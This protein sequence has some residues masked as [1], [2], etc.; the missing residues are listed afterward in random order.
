V[1]RITLGITVAVLGVVLIVASAL[2][3]VIGIGGDDTFGYR[4]I[5]GVIVGA[6]GTVFGGLM[7]FRKPTS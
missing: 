4:Q 7:A 1:S 5:A 2:A 6:L 3:D